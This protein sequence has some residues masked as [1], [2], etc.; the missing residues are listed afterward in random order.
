ML[1]N[2]TDRKPIATYNAYVDVAINEKF[3]I[4]IDIKNVPDLFGVVKTP[5]ELTIGSGI[6]LTKLIDILN[7]NS[8]QNGFEYLSVIAFHIQKI[9]VSFCSLLF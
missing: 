9:A 4:Y 1:K 5:T 6:T 7:S 8:N 2:I 3:V